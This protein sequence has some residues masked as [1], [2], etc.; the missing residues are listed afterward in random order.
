MGEVFLCR[1]RFQTVP[2]MPRGFIRPFLYGDPMILKL[3]IYSFITGS[4]YCVVAL[5]F[6]LVFGVANILNLAHGVFYMISGYLLFSLFM[7]TQNMYVAMLLT[8]FA[9]TLFGAFTYVVLHRVI[10]SPFKTLLATF[11]FGGAVSEILFIVY[12]V[13]TYGLP[14]I[15]EGSVVIF[16]VPIIKQAL[17]SAI[18]ALLALVGFIQFL[19]R[20]DIGRAM[21][22]VAQNV[23]VA[24]LAGINVNRVKFISVVAAAFLA[25]VAGVFYLPLQSLH[26]AMWMNVTILSFVIVVLGGMGSLKG[27]VAA[28]VIAF[29]EHATT[30]SFAE[31]SYVKTGVYLL[32]MIILLM[33][34]PQGL[35]GKYL[36]PLEVQT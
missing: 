22:A 4:I 12:G 30:L 33:F 24:K 35:F 23:E 29:C 20:T 8:L 17:L 25:G 2:C 11:A 9:T 28:Y 18:I 27:I 31:G 32:L 5:G 19:N 7:A 16:G 21:R 13:S 6:S 26:P 36:G 14:N 1:E 3:L 34:R 15:I 10:D